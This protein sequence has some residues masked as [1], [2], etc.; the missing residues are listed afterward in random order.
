[1]N[2]KVRLTFQR[3]QYLGN[4]KRSIHSVTLWGDIASRESLPTA[5]DR[6]A[7]FDKLLVRLENVAYFTNNRHLH[8]LSELLAGLADQYEIEKQLD[9]YE[10]LNAI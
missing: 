2:S 9:I 3:E 6:L 1:M 8:H 7:N 10:A 4:G 5:M